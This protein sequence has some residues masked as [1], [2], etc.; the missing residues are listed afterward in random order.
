MKLLGEKGIA[1]GIHYPTPLPYLKAYEKFNHQPNDFPVSY[2][3]MDKILSLPMFPE[4][5]KEQIDYVSEALMA[6]SVS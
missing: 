6:V 3:Q 5:T 2:R 4:L 1:T